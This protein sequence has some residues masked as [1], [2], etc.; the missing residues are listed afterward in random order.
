[1]ATAIE[2]ELRP[3]AQQLIPK[4]KKIAEERW[5]PYRVEFD[6]LGGAQCLIKIPGIFNA[7]FK[8]A[9]DEGV[10]AYAVPKEYGGLGLNLVEQGVVYLESIKY[11]WSLT[12]GQFFNPGDPPVTLLNAS[13]FPEI[14]DKY[15]KRLLEGGIC[16]VFMTEGESGVDYGSMKSGAVRQGDNYIINGQ[17]WW[18]AWAYAGPFEKNF[19]ITMAKTDPQKR[20][21][22]LTLFIVDHDT[23][24]IRQGREGNQVGMRAW[25]RWEIN[26]ENVVVPEK[27]RVG[28]EGM[29]LIILQNQ[30]SVNYGLA[31][32]TGAGVAECILEH[33]VAHSK[34][35]VRF[36]RPI[37]QFQAVYHQI[38][39]LAIGAAAS[40]A[41]A[42][43]ACLAWD[44]DSTDLEGIKLIIIANRFCSEMSKDSCSKAMVLFAGKAVERGEGNPIEMLWRETTCLNLMRTPNLDRFMIATG[45][46]GEKLRF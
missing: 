20:T 24:G 8:A 38:A 2:E 17:K 21:R 34:Q 16:G 25:P 3:E 36:G 46:I 13:E 32:Y 35:T 1:M 6:S 23:P 40:R 26:F 12:F 42:H 15:M 14:R 44:Q 27:N 41:L 11:G 19:H 7:V 22:G 18:L 39:D 9:M 31:A 33:C 5:L 29:G 45:V 37:S 30:L 4:I 10:W 43:K 28:P